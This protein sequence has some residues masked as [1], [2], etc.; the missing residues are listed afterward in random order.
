[1]FKF[2]VDFQSGNVEMLCADRP[3]ITNLKIQI[4]FF[5]FPCWGRGL[6]EDFAYATVT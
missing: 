3:A 5:G 4:P 1:M 6:A 2:K